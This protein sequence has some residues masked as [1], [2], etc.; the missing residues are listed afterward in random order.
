[1]GG[2]TDKQGLYIWLPWILALCLYIKF[3]FREHFM[4]SPPFDQNADI[5]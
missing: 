4:K 1:M 2:H 3:M 5:Q